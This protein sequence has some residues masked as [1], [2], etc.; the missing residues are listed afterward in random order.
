[1]TNDSPPYDG[2]DTG[3]SSSSG[4]SPSGA[5]DAGGR[6]GSSASPGRRKGKGFIRRHLVLVSLGVVLLLVAGCAGG[7]LYWA[8]HQLSAIPRFHSS[9]LE[10]DPKKNHGGEKSQPL[11]ILLLGADNGGDK[12]TVAADLKDG[13]WTPFVHRSDTMMV[14]HIPAD[15]K[16]V[17]LVSIPRDTWVHIDKY[18]ADAE[19]AK[20]N[21][22]FAYGG[23][24]LAVQ[25]VE[26]LTSLSIDHLAIIDWNGFKGLT[27][28]LGGVRVYTAEEQYDPHN[29]ITWPQGWHTY[30]GEQ[31]LMYVRT[32]YGLPNGDF[33]RIARQQNFLRATMGKLL[34]STK[35]II[36]MT[37]VVN[38][39]TKFLT[40]DDTWDNDEIRNLA[41]DLRG[42][43]AGDVQFV[44][45]P[46]GEYDTVDG[47]SIVRLAPKQSQTLFE[48][49]GSDKIDDYLKRYP[50]AELGG[51]KSVG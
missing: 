47:Q 45:A 25:T 15:R 39:I 34:S 43:N 14:A 41:L 5:P 28:A 23:P 6:A 4:G 9:N 11:N 31:A 36:A 16:S 20:I 21:A 22:A 50:Q 7:Y 48:D 24:D 2:A 18:P 32:R 35:N 51:T 12:E 42:V 38:T 40:I 49:L 8:N 1:M 33:D 44:T 27:T 26:Q 19:H 10:P 3:A 17:Q 46:L 30:E 13:K 37:K 29:D